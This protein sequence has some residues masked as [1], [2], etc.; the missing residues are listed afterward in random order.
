MGITSYNRLRVSVMAIGIALVTFVSTTCGGGFHSSP[1]SAATASS[2]GGLLVH[3]YDASAAKDNQAQAANRKERPPALDVSIAYG[4][5]NFSKA[6]SRRGATD[7]ERWGDMPGAWGSHPADLGSGEADLYNTTPD[8]RNGNPM[9]WQSRVQAHRSGPSG[10]VSP[11]KVALGAEIDDSVRIELDASWIEAP[12]S[13]EA[14]L[15]IGNPVYPM[16][17][18]TLDDGDENWVHGMGLDF[19][20]NREWTARDGYI[21][22]QSPTPSTTV[23]PLGAEEDQSV[24]SFGLGHHTAEYALEMA[25]AMGVFS[26]RATRGGGNT[27]LGSKYDFAAHL[28]G[29]SYLRA[30]FE[31]SGYFSYTYQQN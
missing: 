21:H 30:V 11:I 23:L 16:P 19:A 6:H 2:V 5:N 17:A 4:E 31:S 15:S 10:T 8:G 26:D 13:E 22:V 18:S 20:L 24:I 9:T 27:A 3:I 14:P 12:K 1:G 28:V 7:K 25:Y 29:F